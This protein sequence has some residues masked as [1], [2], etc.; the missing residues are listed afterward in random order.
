[1]RPPAVVVAHV[2]AEDVLELAAADDEHAVEAFAADAADPALDV[3]VC[4]R[5]LD[6]CAD[7]LDHFAGQEDVEGGRE[8]GVAVVE[9]EP[10]PPVA[11]VE[12]VGC[13]NW[14][15]RGGSE[16]VLVDEATE[17]VAPVHAS[18]RRARVASS[19]GD[20][21]AGSGGWRS[22]ARCGLRWL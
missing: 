14:V 6:G 20:G 12:L 17:E 3:C 1:V 5:R 19:R 9:Q 11:I 18:E 8:L 16:F 13:G 2:D 15:S 10:H 7:G 22:R 4:V 21:G